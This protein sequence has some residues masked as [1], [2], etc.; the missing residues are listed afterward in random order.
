M[1][2]VR[3]CLGPPRAYLRFL[4]LFTLS[5]TVVRGWRFAVDC[6]TN[7][8]VTAER[9]R[10]PLLL[11][12]FAMLASPVVVAGGPCVRPLGRYCTEAQL[13]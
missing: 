1:L 11:V 4:G 10:L 13:G 3:R 6:L 12:F 7:R 9:P 5:L 8:P 2:M